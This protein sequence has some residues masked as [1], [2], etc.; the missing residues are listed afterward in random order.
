MYVFAFDV[1]GTEPYWVSFGFSTLLSTKQLQPYTRSD[2]TWHDREMCLNGLCEAEVSVPGAGVRSLQGRQS[3][4]EDGGCKVG[5]EEQEWAGAQSLRPE[6]VKMAWNLCQLPIVFGF[7]RRS[8]HA[9]S[10]SWNSPGPRVR[11]AEARTS[12]RRDSYRTDCCPK[13][14]RGARRKATTRVSPFRRCVLLLRQ[15]DVWSLC[16]DVVVAA[17]HSSKM[18]PGSLLTRNTQGREFGKTV[19]L[20]KLANY[21]PPQSHSQLLNF[22]IQWF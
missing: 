22:L 7:H 13:P 15:Q 5:E 21:K 10:W 16:Q 20:T 3:G 8:W 14:R 1:P 17:S 18:S 9:L 12:R 6:P 2:V 19:L 11:K 4:R